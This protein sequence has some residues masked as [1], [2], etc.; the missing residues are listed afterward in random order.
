MGMLS[1]FKDFAMKGNVVDMAV[2][3]V[4]GGAFSTIV[5]SM[6]NDI[7]MPPIGYVVGKIN[8]SELS[9]SLPTDDKPVTINYGLFI[10]AMIS[11][12]IVAFVLFMVIRSM[13]KLRAQFESGEEKELPTVKPCPD[14]LME[15][16]I[17]AKRCGHCTSPIPAK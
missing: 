11:F 10:Q 9:I 2:G 15:V 16:P 12:I 14:C 13:N 5:K 8:F 6:V 3:I 4:I 1:E 7:I 17:E